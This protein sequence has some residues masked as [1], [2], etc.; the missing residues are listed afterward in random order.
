MNTIMLALHVLIL[1]GGSRPSQNFNSHRTHVDALAKTSLEKGV[2]PERVTIF[3]ADGHDDAPDRAV[4]P[5]FKSAVPLALR[6]H[7]ALEEDGHA[8]LLEDTKFPGFAVYPATRTALKK[9]LF[10]YAAQL[11]SGDVLLIAV[12]DHGEADPTHSMNTSISLWGERWT[13]DEMLADLEP[14]SSKVKITLWM[15]QCYSG[16]FARLAWSR[17][18]LCGAFSAEPSRMAYG[19]YPDLAVEEDIGHF[20]HFLEGLRRHGTLSGAHRWAVRHDDTPDTP[21]L[22]SEAYLRERLITRAAKRHSSLAREIDL[23]LEDA[24]T[25]PH[26][27]DIA[28]LSKIYGLGFLQ[29]FDDIV[30]RLRAVKQLS[31]NLTDWQALWLRILRRGQFDSLRRMG[32]LPKEKTGSLSVSQAKLK[33]FEKWL[34]DHALDRE[35]LEGLARSRHAARTLAEAVDL[36]EAAVIRLSY[37]FV[38]M[39]GPSLLAPDERAQYQRLRACEQQ[40]VWSPDKAHEPLSRTTIQAPSFE[41]L[42]RRGHD[43]QPSFLGVRYGAA[44]KRLG[45]QIQSVVSGSPAM[46]AGLRKGDIIT[47]VDA[48][49]IAHHN[50]LAELTMLSKRAEPTN[51]RVLRGSE[52]L[53][54]PVRLVGLPSKP[55][56]IQIGEVVPPLK[57][58]ALKDGGPIDVVGRGKPQVLFFWATWCGPCKRALPLLT[59]WSTKHGIGVRAVTSEDR[60]TVEAFIAKRG[61]FPF[62]VMLDPSAQVTER[63]DV[64]NLPHFVL[65][66]GLNMLRASEV[67]FRGEIPFAPDLVDAVTKRA[68]DGP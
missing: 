27:V 3:W 21:H 6:G 40:A 49:A 46:A 5:P 15:S 64:S 16:G 19:C 60:E 9:W 2:A 52:T 54:R 22:S 59:A 61:S 55:P 62:P 1:A 53:N 18:N 20:V 67:G 14:V 45:A 7:S 23:G 65:L 57:L 42:E 66:D 51:Y 56:K 48:R 13:V 8:L 68:D 38:D 28:V 37:L 4:L 17:Q 34:E 36:H 44:P 32:V 41:V 25:S 12:T 50:E 63:F 11:D 47:H 58:V 24:D 31:A 10:E 30:R 35:R 26:W 43:V 39:V 33:T 29:R